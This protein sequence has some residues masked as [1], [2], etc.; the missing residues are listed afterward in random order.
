VRWRSFRAT[1]RRETDVVRPAQLE[2]YEKS[3]RI[4]RD[5]FDGEDEEDF[6]IAPDMDYGAQQFAFGVGGQA[7]SAVADGGNVG[8]FNF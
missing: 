4:I 3:V 1:L 8:R 6:D 5:Y 7:A 2:I